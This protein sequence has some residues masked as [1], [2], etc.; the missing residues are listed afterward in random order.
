MREAW[1]EPIPDLFDDCMTSNKA[2][3][4]RT[5]A[6]GFLS[7]EFVAQ[8]FDAWRQRLFAQFL[9]LNDG[10]YVAFMQTD[11]INATKPNMRIGHAGT[12]GL[13]VP[14][15]CVISGMLRLL[16]RRSI[17]K[18]LRLWDRRGGSALACL[19]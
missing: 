2:R 10:A 18:G 17:L 3:Y 15:R 4:N 9:R 13:I 8:L 14:A 5:R 16:G 6:F 7:T 1:S 12:P 19:P 11:P